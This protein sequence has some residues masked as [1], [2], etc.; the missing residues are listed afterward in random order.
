VG[1]QVKVCSNLCVWTDGVKLDLK[2]RSIGEIMDEGM[3]L[4]SN[5]Q[6]K[7]HIE[8]LC[9]LADYTLTEQQFAQILGKARLYNFLPNS[10]KKTID[11]LL[12]TD[13]QLTSV[14]RDYFQDESFCRNES[15]DINL[16]RVYNLLTGA[17]KSSYID[18]FLSRAVNALDFT[19]QIAY[20]L[21][22]GNNHWF[23][24]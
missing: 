8:E 9:R 2:V 7:N 19:N 17:N 11:P 1:F 22:D 23:L 13:T 18:Q 24:S 14:A 20:A 10:Q 21:D 6:P 15:G 4:L 16:W 3:R 12:F 5:Y